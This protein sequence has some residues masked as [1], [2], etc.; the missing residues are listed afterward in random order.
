[1][2]FF[3]FSGILNNWKVSW[4]KLKEQKFSCRKEIKLGNI[5]GRRWEKRGRCLCVQELIRDLVVC[6]FVFNV[7]TNTLLSSYFAFLNLITRRYTG[8]TSCLQDSLYWTRYPRKHSAPNQTNH[9]LG[10]KR[11]VTYRLSLF[12]QNTVFHLKT[13]TKGCCR[14]FKNRSILTVVTSPR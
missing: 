5:Y 1:M 13:K 6:L 7:I 3:C 9:C 14:W 10:W 12:L 2:R 4:I 8:H 11:D